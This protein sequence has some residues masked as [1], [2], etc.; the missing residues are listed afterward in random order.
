MPGNGQNLPALDAGTIDKG[1]EW[2]SGK[3][4]RRRRHAMPGKKVL[5]PGVNLFVALDGEPCSFLAP[6]DGEV[7]YFSIVEQ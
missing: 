2:H 7:I 5:L 3:R 4:Q 1:P 6:T